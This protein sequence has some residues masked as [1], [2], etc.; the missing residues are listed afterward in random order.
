VALEY[1]A[2]RR[3]SHSIAQ[4]A[5]FADQFLVAQSRISER[6]LD[7]QRFQF[8]IE[9]RMPSAP[10]RWLESPLPSDQITMPFQNGV[11]LE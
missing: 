5:Q 4:F 2:H 1:V 6:H 3:A 7:N 10:L 11:W 8:G 9:V